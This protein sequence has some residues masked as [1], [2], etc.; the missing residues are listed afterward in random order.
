VSTTSTTREGRGKAGAA[1][2]ILVAGVI[3][4]ALDL[5]FVYLYFQPADRLAVLRGIAAGLL[6][7]DG[8]KGGGVGIALLGLGLHFVIALG[9]A[10]VF[11]A[12]SRKIVALTRYPWVT[13]PL[14]G[15][16]VWLV[17]NLV[18]LPHSANPPK[19]FP[20]PTWIPVL[21]AHLLCVGL[22]IALAVRFL[23]PP[24]SR[25]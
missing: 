7:R 1:A 9:A 15:V 8:V 11:Y 16:A 6:G 18:V 22:P 3:A 25:V 20:A 23:A 24:R 19:V 2:T 17:M 5:G 12:A 4:G 14:Y 10:A 21:V 13:G